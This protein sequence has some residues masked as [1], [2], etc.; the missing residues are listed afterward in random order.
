MTQDIHLLNIDMRICVCKSCFNKI[1]T[2]IIYQSVE[3]Y[4]FRIPTKSFN[5]LIQ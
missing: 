4:L 2:Q 3:D 5:S 1:L